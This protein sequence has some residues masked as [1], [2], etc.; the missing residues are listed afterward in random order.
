MSFDFRIGGDA[1]QTYA[2]STA[3]NAAA[4]ETEIQSTRLTMGKSADGDTVSISQAGQDKLAAMTSMES[5]SE[6]TGESSESSNSI[7]DQ[8]QKIQE[9]IE[10]VKEEIE[11]LQKDPEKNKDQIAAKQN[12]LMQLQGQLVELQDQKSQA[13]GTNASG[14]TRA[15]GMSNSLT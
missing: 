8:I 1:Q 6:A 13:S 12:E 15:E 7:D 9:Q 10:K 4:E 3:K 14:G 11:K 5:S 2:T